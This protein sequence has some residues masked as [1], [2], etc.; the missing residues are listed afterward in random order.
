MITVPVDHSIVEN[1][2][3]LKVKIPKG[4]DHCFQTD[5][6]NLQGMKLKEGFAVVNDWV[7]FYDLVTDNP[8]SYLLLVFYIAIPN[9]LLTRARYI[10]PDYAYFFI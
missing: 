8:K 5:F 1:N 6:V 9:V 4:N 7:K 3:K 10:L 2:I